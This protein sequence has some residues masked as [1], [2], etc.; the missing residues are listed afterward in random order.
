MENL[1]QADRFSWQRVWLVARYYYPALR[2]QII[3]YPIL[4]LAIALIGVYG[5][6]DSGWTIMLSGLSSFLLWLLYVWSA[7]VFTFHSS[8]PIE[9][10]LPA[11]DSEK[12]TFIVLYLLVGVSVLTFVPG[13][14]VN[15]LN[16][17]ANE[18]EIARA[19]YAL[20][21]RMFW[22]TAMVGVAA[23]LIP[24]TTCMFAVFQSTR[25]RLIKGIT[26]SIVASIG[27][28]IFMIIFSAVITTYIVVNDVQA[29]EVVAAR[30]LANSVMFWIGT[31]GLIYSGLM[32]WLT[33][34]SITHKQI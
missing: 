15:L 25:S 33:V 32:T 5:D 29:D 31:I 23:V 24:M 11:R 3:L 9:V 28:L 14:I 4:S 1:Q 17:Q 34:R 30:S 7:G 12:A 27:M 19:F 13:W 10:S 18:S 20:N 26:W 6:L 2:N 16:P 22:K 8:L 21:P